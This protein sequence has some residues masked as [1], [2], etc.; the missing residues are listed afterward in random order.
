VIPQRIGLRA[1]VVAL[2]L[3]IVAPLG[4]LSVISVQRSWRRQLAN[5]DRQNIATARAISVAIDTQIEATTAALRVFAALHALDVPDIPAFDSLARRLIVREPNWSALVLADLNGRVIAAAPDRDVDQVVTLGTGWAQTVATHDQ[6][7][8]P[9]FDVPGLHG[10]F[11]MIAVPI[12]R[13]GKAT[14]A[15]GARVRADSL[16]AILRQQQSPPNGAVALVD[17]N[18]TIV[19]RTKLEESYIGTRAPQPFIDLTSRMNEGSWQT[20]TREGTHVYAAFSRSG[21][22][23]LTVGLALPRDEVDGPIRRILWILAGAWVVILGVGAGLGMALGQV[24]VRAMRSA[25]QSALALARGGAV[26]AVPSRIAEIDDLST[27]LVLAAQTL[28]ERNR[29]RDEASRLKDEFLMTVSHEL[30]TP[31]TAIYGWA[32]MLSTGQI[33]DGQRQRAID[34]IERNAGALQQLVNDLLDVSR[35][36]SGK[37][38]LEVAT[39]QV[40]EVVGAAIDT[41]RPAAQAKNIRLVTTAGEGELVVS[42]DAGRLQ[43]VIWNLLSNALK[44]TEAGGSIDVRLA[45]N[46]RFA[47]IVI[48]DTG[49]GISPEFLPHVF[50][51]FRQADASSSRRHGGLGVGLALVHDLIVLHGGSV[52]AQSEGEGKGATFTID[53]P[54]VAA[55][56]IGAS[57]EGEGLQADAMTSLDRVRVLLID[58]D[59]DA[60]ELS[61][62]VLEQCGARVKAVSSSAEAIASLLDT[63]RGLMPHVIVSDLGMPAQDGYQ[64]IRQIRAIDNELGRI[65]AVAVTGYATADDVQRALTAGFQLHISKPMDP[66]AFVAAVADLARVDRA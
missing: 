19:A 9:M 43:Q 21:L 62:A 40:P 41:I 66:A 59:K 45:L 12:I 5:V 60:R 27:G 18:N 35:V 11:V 50:E 15:L 48:A 65:P 10:H 28:D 57:I 63:P 64:L 16:G 47:R 51:R 1:I 52:L 33:R 55:Q 23:G 49:H 37:L 32:R 26:A 56:E 22:T 53:L 54:T 7:V 20:E 6:F 58:D 4:V 17:A 14:H 38:R 31:L 2:T 8:S 42:G 13:E 25:S 46:G 29:E 36:V 61:L 30:R 24:I 39:V 34:A 44:F 3:S